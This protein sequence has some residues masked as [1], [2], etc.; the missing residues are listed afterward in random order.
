MRGSR[1]KALKR[2]FKATFG[3]PVHMRMQV[4]ER[5]IVTPFDASTDGL[6]YYVPSEWRRLKAAHKR[7]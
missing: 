2:Q 5:R 4:Q 1:C 3:R 7:G 6:V